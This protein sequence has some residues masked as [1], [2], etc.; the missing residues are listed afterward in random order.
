MAGEVLSKLSRGVSSGETK[1]E[2]GEESGAP[3]TVPDPPSGETPAFKGPFVR[4]A[5]ECRVWPPGPPGPVSPEGAVAF[6]MKTFLVCHNSKFTASSQEEPELLLTSGGGGP[7]SGR[8]RSPH[9]ETEPGS[10][11]NAENGFD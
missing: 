7:C 8:T 4:N 9:P 1:E 11:P 5:E 10:R 2:R 3:T 6:R